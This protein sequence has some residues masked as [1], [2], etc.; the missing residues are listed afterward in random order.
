MRKSGGGVWRLGS[1]RSWSRKR[2]QWALAAVLALAALAA[3]A[4]SSGGG[5]AA[6]QAAAWDAEEGWQEAAVELDWP[7]DEAEEAARAELLREDKGGPGREQDSAGRRAPVPVRVA[8]AL[9]L[10]S[11]GGAGGG[12][13]GG[14]PL[15]LSSGA[16]AAD[17]GGAVRAPLGQ[18]LTLVLGVAN[19]GAETLEPSWVQWFAA[20]A[21]DETA[22]YWIEP[23]VLERGSSRLAGGAELSLA[24]P[25][26]VPESRDHTRVVLRATLHLTELGSGRA[27]EVP[28][29]AR[30]LELVREHSAANAY[31]T[32]LVLLTTALF[33]CWNLFISYRAATAAQRRATAEA[34]GPPEQSSKRRS[35]K[36]N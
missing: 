13:G 2:G 14:A 21:D 22:T 31:T 16:G 7:E 9:L 32:A 36:A 26:L 19:D 30:T 12:R 1:G 10:D 11:G 5:A 27:V 3:T 29:F 6:P 24:V 20:P 15:V 35:K 8:H 17:E 25:L 34:T 23:H 4:A 33:A 18:V 28:A